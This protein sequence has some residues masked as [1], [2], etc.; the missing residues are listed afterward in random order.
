[1]RNNI[2][3]FLDFFYPIFKRFMPIE[4]YRYAT[5]GGL[6][7]M[8]G[9]LVWY[10]C[11]HFVFSRM[12]VNLV[13]YSFEPYTLALLVSSTYSFTLGFL[14]NKYVVFTSSNL[15]G[16][17]QLF[18]YFLSFAFN[19]MLNYFLLKFLVEKFQWDAFISQLLTTFVVIAVSYF[20]QKYFTFKIK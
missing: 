13:F 1:M 4:T 7:T 18:R 2:N 3:Q 16:R 5:C 11:Y 9:F 15:K 17:I 10:V 6:N 19:L 12:V 20:S 8:S 14:L